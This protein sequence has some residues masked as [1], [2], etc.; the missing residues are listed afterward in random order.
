MIEDEKWRINFSTYPNV[1][2]YLGYQ[3]YDA[4]FQVVDEP[5]P[6]FEYELTYNQIAYYLETDNDLLIRRFIKRFG[7]KVGDENV[8][9]KGKENQ[10]ANEDQ[11]WL[12]SRD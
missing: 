2:Q 3:P 9:D 5:I 1:K 8:S 10:V 12:V 6:L 7:E 11:R 4:L